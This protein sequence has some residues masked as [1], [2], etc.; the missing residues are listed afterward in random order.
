MKINEINSK[1]NFSFSCI[2]LWTNLINGKHYVGQASNFYNRMSSYKKLRTNKYLKN[3]FEKYGIENFDISILEK[4]PNNK[5]IL[6]EREQY[7]LDYYKSYNR[8]NGYNICVFAD[9]TLGFKKSEEE[10]QK[11]SDYKKEYYKNPKNREKVSGENNGMYG[12]KHSKE[13]KMEH[14]EFLKEKWKDEEY[15][16]FWSDKMSG[17]NNYFYGKHLFGELNGMYSKKHSEATKKKISEALRGK[18]HKPTHVKKVKCIETGIIYDSQ[19]QAGKEN[20]ICISSINN[21]INGKSKIAGGYHWE[22][23]E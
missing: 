23:V 10:K 18:T 21:V 3:A 11:L 20:N 1:K 17:E 13:W 15:R 9:T 6:T 4:L 5:D 2:Y 19:T 12:K 7:W 14:S 16:K 22:S 8:E